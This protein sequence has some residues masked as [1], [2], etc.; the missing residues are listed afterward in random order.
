MSAPT[1]VTEQIRYDQTI[2]LYYCG[3]PIRPDLQP[4]VNDDNNAHRVDRCS[5]TTDWWTE[6]YDRDAK[7]I[8]Y[9]LSSNN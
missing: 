7:V 3:V 9:F 6:L 4:A 5:D 2:I 8:F 1:T